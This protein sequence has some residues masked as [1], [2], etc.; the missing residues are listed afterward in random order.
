VKVLDLEGKGLKISRN[1]TEYIIEYDFGEKGQEVDGTRTI[2][3]DVIG[4]VDS[5][6][7]LGSFVQR[8]GGFGVWM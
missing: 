6:K 7:Y 5:F 8:D 4:E 1:K 3:G 2:S